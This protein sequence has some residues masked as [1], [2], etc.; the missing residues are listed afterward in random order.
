MKGNDDKVREGAEAPTA[1]TT[2]TEPTAPTSPTGNITGKGRG[3]GGRG[4]T[5]KILPRDLPKDERERYKWYAERFM[6]GEISLGD[7]RE[8]E[9]I[10]N[11]GKARKVLSMGFRY[12]KEDW[13]RKLEEKQREIDE[14]KLKVADRGEVGNE[15][16]EDAETSGKLSPEQVRELAR[17]VAEARG[18]RVEKGGGGRKVDVAW[19]VSEVGKMI[20]EGASVADILATYSDVGFNTLKAA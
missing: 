13:E 14:L 3:G 8:L 15:V 10:A 2:P 20:E 16:Q 17:L 9:G 4:G 12:L 6:E 1:P 5:P 19:L 7:I 18:L 11:W